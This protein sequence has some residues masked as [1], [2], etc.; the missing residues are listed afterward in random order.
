[1]FKEVHEVS[2]LIG[3]VVTVV[4]AVLGFVLRYHRTV[5]KRFR[6]DKDILCDDLAFFMNL[7]SKYIAELKERG[8]VMH[9]SIKVAMRAK[10]RSEGL[11]FSGKFT[12]GRVAASRARRGLV[13]SFYRV[14]A[15]IEAMGDQSEQEA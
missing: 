1:M 5:L 8:V 14:K 12:P 15:T 6:R 2:G 9:P 4:T 7:E 3:A 11:E 13:P 10:V